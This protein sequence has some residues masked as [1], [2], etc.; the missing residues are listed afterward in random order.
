MLLNFGLIYIELIKV[1]MM[2]KSIT[3]FTLF[4]L[5]VTVP[6]LASV[7]TIDDIVG[8]YIEMDYQPVQD[9]STGE[10]TLQWKSC[11]DLSIQRA[12]DDDAIEISGFWRSLRGAR[13]TLQAQYDDYDGTIRIPAGSVVFVDTQYTPSTGVVA[14]VDI[15]VY[16]FE[17]DETGE[18][19][20]LSQRPILYKYDAAQNRWSCGSTL[21]ITTFIDGEE[22]I[23][24]AM[25]DS[26]LIPA[27]GVVYNES[28]SFEDGVKYPYGAESRPCY[29][30]AASNTL[31]NLIYTD[32][33]GHGA[34][35]T[36]DPQSGT[37][38]AS[39]IAEA[40]GDISNPYKALVGVDIDP[41][42]YIPT[43]TYDG[44]INVTSKE[45]DD[46]TG[47]TT[48][49]YIPSAIYPA[50]VDDNYQPQIDDSSIYEVIE[51]LSIVYTP[52]A[53]SSV[54]SIAADKNKDIKE[55]TYYDLF[56]RCVTEP[57]A[58]A[59]V[60]KKNVYTDG[61]TSAEKIIVK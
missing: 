28:Y 50:S 31:Y 43:P 58:G 4:C 30:D 41:E 1:K 2:K 56:G 47:A 24:E 21:V 20:T 44:T 53:S 26:E 35:V 54:P 51:K 23:M 33:F 40:S 3:L 57:Q 18:S 16:A 5:G 12:Q 60:I 49:V 48:F 27:N 42:T 6:A 39:L 15:K 37:I 10:T 22:V 19:G 29:I 13:H 34:R 36:F 25:Y 46:E 9:S 38:P 7:P 52:A 59:L 17:W 45:V 32:Q 61:T 11:N 55:S 14:T 8:D